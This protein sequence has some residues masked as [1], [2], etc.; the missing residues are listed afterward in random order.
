[1]FEACPVCFNYYDNDERVKANFIGRTKMCYKCYNEQPKVIAVDFDATLT[2][3]SGWKGE[4]HKGELLDGAKEF[5]ENLKELGFDIYIVT[6]RPTKGILEW[7]K[8]NKIDHLIHT[9]T[10]MK[11]A[12][13]C[14]ID[15]RAISFNN[16]FDETL[17]KVKSFVPWYKRSAKN[18]FNR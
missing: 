9:I 3:Y 5:L 14:Y 1:M 11:V 12:A 6:S 8:E 4:K 7:L 15:D 18:E 16:N 13:Y 10:N 17:E 2:N